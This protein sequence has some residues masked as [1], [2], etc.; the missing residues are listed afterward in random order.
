MAPAGVC[1]PSRHA[2]TVFKGDPTAPRESRGSSSS[3]HVVLSGFHSHPRSVGGYRGLILGFLF[4]DFDLERGPA[5][6]RRRENHEPV[7]PLIAAFSGR[8]SPAP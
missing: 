2:T 3:Q 6:G 7:I 1:P 8:L 4:L 5:A